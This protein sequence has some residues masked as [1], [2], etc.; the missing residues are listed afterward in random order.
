[1]IRVFSLAAALARVAALS[2]ALAGVVLFVLLHRARAEIDERLIDVGSQL[3][4]YPG[5]PLETERVL[6]INGSVFHFRSQTVDASFD[7][8]L[9]HH[10]T[11]CDTNDGML[12]E[13]LSAQL[14]KPARHGDGVSLK[15]LATTEAR[16]DTR[17][18]VA[19][20]DLGRRSLGLPV[21]IER[22][23]RLV[24]T[25]SLGE[26][27]VARYAYAEA[28]KDDPTQ[29]LV[30]TAWSEK[31]ELSD[32]LLREG[33]DAAGA[34]LPGLPRPPGSHRIL[35][36]SE[37]DAPTS[38]AVYRSRGMRS[39]QVVAFY[40]DFLKSRGWT[41][42]QSDLER[43]ATIGDSSVLAAGRDEQVVTVVSS[44]SDPGDSVSVLLVAG[45]R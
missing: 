36:A 16:V 17:G 11:Q 19:C 14:G 39:E 21:L 44:T 8:V 27:G 35:S 28:R 22:L 32:L 37:V 42:L 2:V 26:L 43:R 24:R 15:S 12:A 7:E 33:A 1:M 9:D 31:L 5:S 40:R 45:S 38:V 10:R 4:Q 41:V 34:D 25:G 29:A 3:M 6:R 18:F 20:V 30:L 23:A 13:Q